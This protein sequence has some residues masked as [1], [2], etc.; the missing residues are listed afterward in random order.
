M[1]NE[2]FMHHYD[3]LFM[4]STTCSF[5]IRQRQFAVFEKFFGSS[6]KAKIVYFFNKLSLVN[7]PGQDNFDA[8]KDNAN[9]KDLLEFTLYNFNEDVSLQK[10]K[11]ST[12]LCPLSNKHVKMQNA[13]A[14]RMSPDGCR[15]VEALQ[16]FHSKYQK[17]VKQQS[18][19]HHLM[20]PLTE[21]IR[22]NP[23]H[24]VQDKN[25]AEKIFS[26]VFW[27]YWHILDRSDQQYLAEAFNKVFINFIRFTSMM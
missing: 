18:S 9:L 22:Y 27:Q 6:L 24:N 10:I 13:E 11:N 5:E 1:S 25:I 16:P 17:Y 3:K 19:L 12:N 4:L 7:K 15:I 23:E 2:L 26:K 14:L 21:I 20:Q 8:Y